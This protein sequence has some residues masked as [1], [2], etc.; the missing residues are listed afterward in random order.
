M[1][2]ELADRDQSADQFLAMARQQMVAGEVDSA[3]N[4]VKAVISLTPAKA[5]AWYLMGEILSGMPG[6]RAE[7]ADAYKRALQLDPELGSAKDGIDALSD[8]DTVAPQEPRGRDEWHRQAQEQDQTNQEE[9]AE[10]GLKKDAISR[11]RTAKASYN[12]VVAHAHVS[13]A[14]IANTSSQAARATTQL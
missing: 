2:A 1:V 3:H 11:A 5:R 13:S 14:S 4:T 8:R 12:W 7:A 9:F 10:K 6:S